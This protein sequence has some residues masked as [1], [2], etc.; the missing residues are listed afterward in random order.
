MNKKFQGMGFGERKVEKTDLEVR[1]RIEFTD[2]VPD[3]LQPWI[4]YFLDL[5]IG[6]THTAAVY[7]GTTPDGV[8]LFQ[9]TITTNPDYREKRRDEEG[10]V[11]PRFIWTDVPDFFR[12]PIIRWRPS[13][14]ETLENAAA[15]FD[16]VAHLGKIY[17]GKSLEKSD[18]DTQETS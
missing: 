14:R 5:T 4:G 1:Y 12:Q 6:E 8:H 10:P 18:S 13:T 15:N 17:N 9:P 7:R 2:K 3:A 11:P 16:Q